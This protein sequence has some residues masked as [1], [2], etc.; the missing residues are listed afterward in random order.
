MINL[1]YFYITGRPT[2]LREVSET[3]Y[4]ALNSP[5]QQDIDLHTYGFVYC[6]QYEG[7][8]KLEAL[9]TLVVEALFMNDDEKRF[10][11]DRFALVQ[12]CY[13][14]FGK[15]AHVYKANRAKRFDIDCDLCTTPFS[16]LPQTVL[17]D[18]YD[19]DTR[20]IYRFRLSDLVSLANR[21]LTHAP[22]FFVE[23]LAVRNPYTNITFTKSQLYHIYFALRASP[24][25]MPV[26]YHLWFLVH[27][28]L[29]LFMR[30][31]ECTLVDLAILD[32]VKNGST[33]EWSEQTYE[34]VDSY[35]TWLNVV[36][37][38]PED[39]LVE[40]LAPFMHDYLLASCSLSPTLRKQAELRLRRRLACFRFRNPLFGRKIYEADT[41]QFI[42]TMSD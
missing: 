27:F 12:R 22:E 36:D 10:L 21:S 41:I 18:V 9:K 16:A 23:P 8:G 2:D 7:L 42:G 32:F 37:D 15:L 31:N 20:T 34:M 26:L 29:A 1:F 11:I 17:T 6:V 24:L 3:D 38:F 13:W 4:I 14:A 40:A 30:R 35:L 39:M 33:E 19:E 5:H 28:D 25:V